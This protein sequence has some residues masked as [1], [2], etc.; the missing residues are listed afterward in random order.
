MK[1]WGAQD[2]F[3][4]QIEQTVKDRRAILASQMLGAGKK[5]C[6]DCDEPIP[7]ARREAYPSC[8]KC[9]QCQAEAEGGF[10]IRR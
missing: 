7:L 2:D 3:Q 4:E 5:V 6:E 10:F 9:V 8:T 1:G